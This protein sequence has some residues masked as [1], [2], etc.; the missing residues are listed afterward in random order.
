MIK[1]LEYILG[2]LLFLS[3]VPIA[4]MSQTTPDDKADKAERTHRKHVVRHTVGATAGRIK[5]A[6]SKAY[7]APANAVRKAKAHHA[8][9]EKAESK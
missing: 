2:I 6:G 7:H 5:N 3:L 4:G 9:D 8:A 1:K